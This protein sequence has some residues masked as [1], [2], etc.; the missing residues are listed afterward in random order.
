MTF[1]TIVL[2]WIEFWKAV[3]KNSLGFAVLFIILILIF[4]L[5]ALVI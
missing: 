2:F 3:D 1:I 4:S 5:I